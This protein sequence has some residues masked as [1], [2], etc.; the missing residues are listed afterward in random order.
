MAKS[1][2]LEKAKKKNLV[3]KGKSVNFRVDEIILPNKKTAIR[4]FLEHPGAVAI[5]AEIDGKILFVRQYRYPVGEE[6]IEIPAGKLVSKKD[7][8]VKRAI[9]E[10]EEE[11]G[12]KAGKIK[13]LIDYWP[14]PAFS[15]EVLKIYFACN[16]KKTRKNPD[17]DEFLSTV[18]LTLPEA[19]SLIKSGK[20]KDSKTIIAI[21]YYSLYKEEIYE[22]DRKG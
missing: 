7:D 5:I 22:M 8:P 16:L 9:S 6:T 11:T 19:L 3:Y 18:K 21:L 17:E 13:H 10:L 1:V 4:E 14:T 15:D 2:F 20:I 12:Y